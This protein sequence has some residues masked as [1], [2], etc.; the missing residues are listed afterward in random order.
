L[1]SPKTLLLNDTN[2]DYHEGVCLCAG[3]FVLGGVFA[4]FVNAKKPVT[5][6]AA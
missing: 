6:D 1:I 2:H 3:A 5:R 4:L